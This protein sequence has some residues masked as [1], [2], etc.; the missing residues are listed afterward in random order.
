MASVTKYVQVGQKVSVTELES[1]C[2]LT[3]VGADDTGLT[4]VENGTDYLLL[5]DAAGEVRTRL[6]SYLVRGVAGLPEHTVAPP[7]VIVATPVISEVSMPSVVADVEMPPVVEVIAPAA[8]VEEVA[9]VP[10]TPVVEEAPSIEP[11]PAMTVSE[12]A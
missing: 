3:V 4:V 1:G 8:V 10:M 6:P 7:S 12:A 11:A 5:E 2:R 9:A